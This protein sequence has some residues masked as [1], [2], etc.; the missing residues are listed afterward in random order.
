MKIVNAPSDAGAAAAIAP[1]RAP[2][3]ESKAS[4]ATLG[5]SRGFTDVLA[6][7]SPKGTSRGEDKKAATSTSKSGSAKDA[8]LAHTPTSNELS[9]AVP[10]LP[11]MSVDVASKHGTSE[12]DGFGRAGVVTRDGSA[13]DMPPMTESTPTVSDAS[14]GASGVSSDRT[15]R[16]HESVA[17]GRTHGLRELAAHPR[18]ALT[19]DEMVPTASSL[20]DPQDRRFAA[21][22]GPEVSPTATSPMDHVEL[23]LR[24]LANQQSNH[25]PA[26]ERETPSNPAPTTFAP[27]RGTV[28]VEFIAAHTGDVVGHTTALESFNAPGSHGPGKDHVP[29]PRTESSVA[30]GVGSVG[31]AASATRAP[32]ADVTPAPQSPVV[33]GTFPV[34]HLGASPRA[35]YSLQRAIDVSSL[36]HTIS[37][38]LRGGDGN[39]SVTLAMRP[40]SLGQVQAVVSLRGNDLH[41]AITPETGAGHDAIASTMTSLK[42][43]LSRGG[44]NVNVTLHDPGQ[45]SD[46]E[47][48]ERA[49]TGITGELDTA[50]EVLATPALDAGLIHLV[51]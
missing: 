41:V 47:R 8:A 23:A 2:V 39:Y 28:S 44:V 29:A 36:A 15:A 1:S 4:P 20:T 33:A 3:N 42:E 48:R 7:E 30:R 13:R 27:H 25:A 26:G 17:P 34:G 45:S 32:S 5:D 6:N 35:S 18:V 14:R 10:A 49:F 51:L 43:E 31:S 40:I 37:R 11:A 38:P 19:P 12:A 9:L 50:V 21:G 22:P 16:D 46:G 24:E